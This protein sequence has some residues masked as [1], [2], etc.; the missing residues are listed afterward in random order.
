M[1]AVVVDAAAGGA[2]KAPVYN[3]IGLA[4]M[5]VVFHY[6]MILTPRGHSRHWR[7]GVDKKGRIL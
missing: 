1:A 3:R 2:G 4:K 5:E 6:R 7:R